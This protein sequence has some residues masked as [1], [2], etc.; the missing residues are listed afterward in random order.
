ML[1]QNQKMLVIKRNGEFQKISFDKIIYRIENLSKG[2]DI[3]PIVVAQKVIV[4]IHDKIKTSK[5]DELTGDICISMLSENLDYGKLASRVVISNSHK[6]TSPSFSEAM[7][8]LFNNK[9]KQGNP[10]P[11]IAEEF[12]NFVMEH[13]TKLNS[14]INY[15]RDFDFSYFAYKTLERAYLAKMSNGKIIERIQHL[16]MRVSVGM[17]L[18]DLR[19]AIRSYEHMSQKF[20]IHATPTLYNSGTEKNQLAS[21]FLLGTE[22]SIEG[23][24]DTLK[25]CAMISKG[26]GG[27]GMHMSCIR[28]KGSYINGTNG[29]TN[30]IVPMARVFNETSKYVNQGGRRPGSFAFYMEPHHPEIMAFLSLKKNHGN[31][32]ERCRNLFLALWISD[33]FMERVEANAKWST[34]NDNICPGLLDAYGDDYKKLYLKYES[35]GKSFKTY[36]ARDVWDAILAAQN[37]TGVPY[38]SFKD[39][40][41]RKSNQMNVGTIKSSNL[42]C[43]IVEYSDTE[44]YAVCTLASVN[45]AK[46]VNAKEKTFDY[47]RLIEV[48]DILVNN[49]NRVID[50]NHYPVPQCEKSN[51]RHRPIGIGVQGLANVFA[52]MRIPFE[53]QEAR[54]LNKKIFETMYY[55]AMMASCKLAKRDGPYSTFEGSPISQGKFQ[56]DLWDVKP[57]DRYDW[58]ALRKDIME[59]GVRN[60]LCIA[61][62]PTAS[63]SQILGNNECFEPFTSNLYTRRTIAGDFVVINEYL[64]R[65]LMELNLWN[66]DM[67]DKIIFYNG[68]VQQ[69]EE[70][71]EDIKALYKTAWEMK[72]KALIDLAADRGPFVCQTQSM[73]LFFEE[74]KDKEL[75]GAFFYG[76]KRGLKTGSYYIR[77]RPKVQAQQFT[78]DPEKFKKKLEDN[79]NS[80]ETE[81]EVCEMCSS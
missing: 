15:E 68:S 58:G 40:V 81:Y 73:N 9:D 55:G 37:E 75:T 13:R 33:L 79:K 8:T 76:H 7:T 46:M 67:K 6:N 32:D 72:Q 18:N 43:E 44:E 29:F 10:R 36:N 50:I 66:K 61:L 24:F 19:S 14:V 39:H 45:L 4:Q 56:F 23:I 65:D 60:S 54:E 70:I 20:F 27:I 69:I 2:L 62:M 53:S 51:M 48:M 5:L 3:D 63:T 38:M 74:P 17:H 30:G 16:L 80:G 12:Y 57:S 64:V 35:E 28:S 21:C 42:C 25:H 49:L 41:N 11:V 31:E 22:D 26:A 77:T 78:I 52:M 59:N 34:F 47:D 1:E 71:P